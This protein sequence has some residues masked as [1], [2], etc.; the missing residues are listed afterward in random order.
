MFL[1][2]VVLLTI[3]NKFKGA[4]V[5]AVVPLCTYFAFVKN[6]HLS[7]S[8]VVLSIAWLFCKM[9]GHPAQILYLIIVLY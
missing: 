7:L 1:S 3:V 2:V 8:C 5:C 9:S 6:I 4:F